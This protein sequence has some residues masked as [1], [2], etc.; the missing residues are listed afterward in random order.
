MST[1]E[2]ILRLMADKKASDVYLSAQSPALIKING[3]SLPINN[4][5]LPSEAPL[6]LLAE[7]LPADRI[8][9]LRELGEL[10]MALAMAGVG[11]FR[12]SGFRQRSTYAAVIRFIPFDIPPLG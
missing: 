5:V 6:N 9:E 10:N 3:Q 4:Q 1:M 12:I 2:R 11:N 8:E 7:I